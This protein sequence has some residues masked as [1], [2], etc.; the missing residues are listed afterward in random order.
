M[1]LIEDN[2][3]IFWPVSDTNEILNK[4]GSMFYNFSLIFYNKKNQKLLN[5]YLLL[6]FLR[7]FEKKV[8]NN[9]NDD[10]L[11]WVNYNSIYIKMLNL[12]YFT[13]Y[14]LYLIIKDNI[15]SNLI[16][17]QVL[18]ECKSF[19]INNEKYLCSLLFTLVRRKKIN[20]FLDLYNKCRIEGFYKNI[21]Y[22]MYYDEDSQ[23]L[24]FN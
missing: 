16:D 24:Y 5:P 2:N 9:P 1:S 12:N 15:K 22:L 3:L 23:V 6:F 8:K 14:K 13:L 4:D 19:K 10:K 11:N 20:T 18:D 7:Y 17:I 21:N